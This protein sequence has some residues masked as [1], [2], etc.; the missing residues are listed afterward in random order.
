MLLGVLLATGLAFSGG[1]VLEAPREVK[2]RLVE[3]INADRK[4]AGLAPVEY[5]AELSKA[6]DAHCRDMVEGDYVSHWNRDGWKPYLRY[7]HAGI[8]DVTSENIHAVWSTHFDR[9]RIWSYLLEGHRDFMAEQPP[10]DGHRRS[11]LDPA[12]TH[13]GIGVAFNQ[14]G[15][16]LIELFGGRYA[17]LEP[18]PLRAKLGDNLTLRGRLLRSGDK[19]YGIEVFYEPPP[20]PMTRQQ[21]KSTYSYSLPLE[22]RMEGRRLDRGLYSDG[23]AGTVMTSGSLFSLPIS[24]WKGKPGVYTLAVWLEGGGK[25]AY[26]GA[27]T[28]II[29]GER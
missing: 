26:L 22:K 2:V 23:T 15:L 3:V 25:E 27:T 14:G 4:A 16:R 17:E 8:R 28:S 20:E 1:E 13:V 10:N 18:L 19:V 12:H 9:E 29:V 21:L 6:A 5:S 11:I 24:F 7:A